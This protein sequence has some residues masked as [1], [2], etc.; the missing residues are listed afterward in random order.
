MDTITSNDLA[1]VIYEN[2]HYLLAISS[3]FKVDT[4][5][6][7]YKI[8]DDMLTLGRMS[9]SKIGDNWYEI[10]I[11]EDFTTERIVE[12]YHL[13]LD[14]QTSFAGVNQ[15]VGNN[16]NIWQALTIIN[17]HPPNRNDE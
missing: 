16:N 5:G 11:S 12:L 17:N 9:V 4:I 3:K 2:C 7:K 6:D 13:C 14:Y 15:E 1:K 10:L 8:I